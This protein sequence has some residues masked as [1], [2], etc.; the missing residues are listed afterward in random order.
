MDSTKYIYQEKDRN[1]YNGYSKNARI[2]TYF[3][4]MTFKAI[5]QIQ[6]LIFPEQFSEQDIVKFAFYF[7]W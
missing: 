5:R 6:H 7:Y 4:C 2:K 3:L 1:F